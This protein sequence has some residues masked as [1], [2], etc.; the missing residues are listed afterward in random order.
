[1]KTN[2]YAIIG[3]GRL[4]RHMSHYFDLLKVNYLSW[5]RNSDTTYN[6]FS[7]IESPTER[8][9]CTLDKANSVLILISDDQINSFIHQ[10]NGTLKD[11]TIIHFSGALNI[12]TAYSL[13]PLMSFSDE[14]YD[15]DFY[16]S[17]NFV[18]DPKSDLSK[19]IPE[20]Q[21]SN[22]KIEPDQKSLYHSLCVISGNFPQ[23]LWNECLNI[24]QN[25][26]K[27]P[28]HILDIYIDRISKN[29]IQA[30][31]KSIT[32][33]LSRGDQ[34]TLNKNQNSLTGNLLQ[35]LYQEFRTQFSKD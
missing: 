24:A 21:N 8:L 12:N 30:K 22:Y 2:S 1:M 18:S 28:P 27:L 20:F 7:H 23:L 14:L 5:S 10:N 29:F 31:A 4:A 3:S 25:E 15:L 33:P 26:L 6:T 9:K 34:E 11:K 32:G 13:H 16:K 19:L 17:I 35:P